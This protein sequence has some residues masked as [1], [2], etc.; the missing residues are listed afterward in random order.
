MVDIYSRLKKSKI[1]MGEGTTL[2]E[3][4]GSKYY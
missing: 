2:R 3:Q 4:R 1:R